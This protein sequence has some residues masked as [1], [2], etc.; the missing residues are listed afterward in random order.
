MKTVREIITEGLSDQP[1]LEMGA[2]HAERVIQVLKAAG[3]VIVP[4]EPTLKMTYVGECVDLHTDFDEEG[5]SI[6]SAAADCWRQMIK[7]RPK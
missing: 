7:A 3:R 2:A 4:I 1:G 6:G 5:R